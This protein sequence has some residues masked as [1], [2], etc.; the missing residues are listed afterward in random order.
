MIEEPDGSETYYDQVVIGAHGDEAL[1]M[2]S[3][4]TDAERALLGCFSYQD[5]VAVLHRDS[6]LSLDRATWF[7]LLEEARSH[8]VP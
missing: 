2:L 4:A 6:S 7:A 8:R 1:A 5:N 3:D